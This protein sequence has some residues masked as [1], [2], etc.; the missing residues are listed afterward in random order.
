M[1]ALEISTQ[2]KTCFNDNLQAASA[3][4]VSKYGPGPGRPA[5]ANPAG[6]LY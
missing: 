5:A 4:G 1:A 6:M 3:P 2:D